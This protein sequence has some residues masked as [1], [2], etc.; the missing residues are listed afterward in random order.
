MNA[1]F[2]YLQC[3]YRVDT[4]WNKVSAMSVLH[5]TKNH[6]EAVLDIFQP[7]EYTRATDQVD[8]K[9]HNEVILVTNILLV[10]K[11]LP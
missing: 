5:P 2:I 1:A 6:L 9:H 11:F 4:G 7:Y 10:E 8:R 3:L